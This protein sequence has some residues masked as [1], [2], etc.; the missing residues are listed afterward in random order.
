MLLVLAISK[1]AYRLL[2]RCFLLRQLEV[3]RHTLRVN[4]WLLVARN[5]FIRLILLL[6]FV[7]KFGFLSQSVRSISLFLN[8]LIRNVR[9]RV[10]V[11]FIL[12][13]LQLFFISL[14]VLSRSDE[15]FLAAHRFHHCHLVLHFLYFQNTVI[16][17]FLNFGAIISNLRV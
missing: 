1:A 3:K 9:V 5:I 16:R 15:F 8:F 12:V 14:Q 6:F 17:L 2:L 13:G 7:V 10:D 11:N 4:F